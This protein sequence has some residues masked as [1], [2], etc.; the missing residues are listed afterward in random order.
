LREGGR[1]HDPLSISELRDSFRIFVNYRREDSSGQA[2]RLYDALTQRFGADR[3][4]MDIDT[5]E[6]GLDFAEV[7]DKTIGSVEVFLALIGPRWFGAPDAQGTPRLE[8]PD[9]FVRLEIEAALRPDVRVIPVLVA[10]A[11]MPSSDR[12]PPSLAALARR[13]AVEVRDTSWRSDIERLIGALERMASRTAAR[14][15]GTNARGSSRLI[16]RS[17]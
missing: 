4:F 15:R 1:R 11:V 16:S 5:I 10:G 3:V 13:N 2:G 12:L 7:I 17:W 6:P 14:R 8:K 9:D